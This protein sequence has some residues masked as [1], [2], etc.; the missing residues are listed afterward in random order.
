MTPDDGSHQVIDGP[1]LANM[2]TEDKLV[3]VAVSPLNFGRDEVFELPLKFDD[4]NGI[5]PV[6]QCSHSTILL[7]VS[8]SRDR[9]SS[10]RILY[11]LLEGCGLVG[12][13]WS[14]ARRCHAYFC[15]GCSEYP[16]L[17]RLLQLWSR[18]R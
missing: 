1:S 2:C 15:L 12:S 4:S 3:E 13:G 5:W 6:V 14:P 8:Q 10:L 16:S 11:S 17:W 18:Q 9:V 7:S